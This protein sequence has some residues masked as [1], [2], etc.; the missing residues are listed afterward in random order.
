MVAGVRVKGSS[1]QTRSAWEWYLPLQV[2]IIKKNH[3]P[4]QIGKICLNKKKTYNNICELKHL[5]KLQPS[6]SGRSNP[7]QNF[8][9]SLSALRI[10]ETIGWKIWQ[11][12]FKNRKIKYFTAV[13]VPCLG[14]SGLPFVLR[15]GAGLLCRS[16]EFLRQRESYFAN[17]KPAKRFIF[18]ETKE[19]L[20]FNTRSDNSNK[21]FVLCF[22]YPSLT[23]VQFIYLPISAT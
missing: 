19:K 7:H 11:N 21:K 15:L 14:E 1:R 9:S 10:L 2:F 13:A 20:S 3:D 4:L 5:S 18:A 12:S 16:G 22:T 17:S 8:S 23:K 6:P